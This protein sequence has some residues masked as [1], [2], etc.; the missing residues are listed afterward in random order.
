[1]TKTE[2]PLVGWLES[3]LN[4]VKLNWTDIKYQSPSA[5]NT[6]TY[7]PLSSTSVTVSLT[8]TDP[9]EGDKTMC[10]RKNVIRCLWDK[11][12]DGVIKATKC[13]TWHRV[14]V[15]NCETRHSICLCNCETWHRGCLFDCETWHGGGGGCDCDM[16]QGMCVT[17]R[18]DTGFVCAWLRDITQCVQLWDRTQGGVHVWLDMTQYVWL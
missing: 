7:S 6:C 17:V 5:Y 9:G 12:H 2:L 8:H 10:E 11:L 13:M 18:H 4:W 15:C 14:C 3:F 1:M 16:T